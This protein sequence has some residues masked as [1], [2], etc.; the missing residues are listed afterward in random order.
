MLS[1]RL[2]SVAQLFI[3]I[4]HCGTLKFIVLHQRMKIEAMVQLK[5]HATSRYH[6]YNI[7]LFSHLY[8]KETK[9]HKT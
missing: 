2:V 8:E 6:I 5:S 3:T 4:N 7:G 9:K 1:S